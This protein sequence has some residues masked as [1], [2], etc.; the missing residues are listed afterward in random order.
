SS[1]GRYLLQGGWLVSDSVI[2]DGG[3]YAQ[4]GGTNRVQELTVKGGG[5]FELVGGELLTSN[6]VVNP[7]LYVRGRFTQSG[8]MHGVRDRLL[9]QGGFYENPLNPEYTLA[10]GSVVASNLQI[11]GATLSISSNAVLSTSRIE[12]GAHLFVSGHGMVSNSGILAI[13]GKSYATVY[14]WPNLQFDVSVV[15]TQYLGRLQICSG[16][17][18]SCLGAPALRFAD[19]HTLEWTGPLHIRFPGPG[20]DT[21]IFFGT[22]AQALTAGQ[23]AWISF[24]A[25]NTNYPAMLLA[26]GELV[27]VVPAT[28]GFTNTGTSLILS[29]SG[30][31]ELLTATNVLG[32][33]LLI[34]GAVSPMTTTFTDPERYFRL[35]LP[36]P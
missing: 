36:A 6:S 10:G 7:D 16:A 34:P 20:S 1:A 25:N 14:D 17:L 33:Y 21:H 29:W 30:S 26:N 8:G 35:R 23:L 22:N 32:P 11:S 13:S 18:I 28:L 15:E 24:V 12:L 27:P 19:S 3:Y 9:V 2:S 4:T 31:Y 5:D